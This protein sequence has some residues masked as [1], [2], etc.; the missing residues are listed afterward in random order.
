MVQ[1]SATRRDCIVILWISLA[2]FA[3]ITLY[4]SSGRVIPKV[5]IYF[6]ID[7]VWK[8]LEHT[9]IFERSVD[10]RTSLIPIW[11]FTKPTWYRFYDVHH[12]NVKIFLIFIFPG[13]WGFHG[14]VYSDRGLLGSCPVQRCGWIPAFRSTI[15]LPSSGFFRCFVCL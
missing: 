1:L 9:L 13:I 11:Q 2:S 6:V 4:V 3:V 15:L 5:S 12:T 10:S 8:L 7:S 14:D